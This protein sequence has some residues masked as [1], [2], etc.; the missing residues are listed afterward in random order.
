MAQDQARNAPLAHGDAHLANIPRFDK[1]REGEIVFLSSPA[2]KRGALPIET[3]VKVTPEGIVK[4]FTTR[5]PLRYDRKEIWTL[6]GEAQITALGYNRCNQFAGV[7]FVTPENLAGPDGKPVNNPFFHYDDEDGSLIYIRVRRIGVGRNMV[8]NRIAIDLTLTYDVDHYFQQEIFAKIE[9]AKSGAEWFEIVSS[10]AIPDEL[11]RDRHKRIVLCEGGISIIL[12]LKSPIVVDLFQGHIKRVKFAERNANTICERNILKRFI[13][14][15][16][17]GQTGYVDIVSWPQTDLDFNKI[18]EAMKRSR[19]GAINIEGKPVEIV[20]EEETIRDK[21][22]IDGIL[23][24]DN[25]DETG[26]SSEPPVDAPPLEEATEE[27]L[28]KA[29]A[30]IRDHVRKLAEEVWSIAFE[31]RGFNSLADVAECKAI[32]SLEDLLSD[33]RKLAAKNR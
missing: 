5:L 28:S 1:L 25:E 13:A 6:Q 32:W 7:S 26:G 4:R 30:E 19:E 15:A 12:D 20:R 24:G 10:E 18:A 21:E 2:V 33:L 27:M 9:K 11:R 22:E 16:G 17:L 8:G 14:V 29:R 23:A 3:L 31:A